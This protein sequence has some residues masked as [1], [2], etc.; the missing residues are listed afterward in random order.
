MWKFEYSVLFTPTAKYTERRKIINL[1]YAIYKKKSDL[2]NSTILFVN[3]Y[4]SNFLFSFLRGKRLFIIFWRWFSYF[5]ANGNNGC[6]LFESLNGVWDNVADWLITANVR[7]RIWSSY[8]PI[9]AQN[10]GDI[11]V[12]LFLISWDFSDTI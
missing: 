11:S 8:E 6:L 3:K 9:F 4:I 5:V 1:R 10:W 2:R 12:S 7:I